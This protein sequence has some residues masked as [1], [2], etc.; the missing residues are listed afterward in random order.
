MFSSIKMIYVQH[1]DYRKQTF[2]WPSSSPILH[3]LNVVHSS[4]MA[5]RL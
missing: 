5:R 1:V 4:G 3:N 2:L